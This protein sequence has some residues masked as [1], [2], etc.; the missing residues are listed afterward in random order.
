VRVPEALPDGNPWPLISIV[1]PS[2]NQADYLEATI[3]SVLLQGYPNLEYII[4]DGGSTDGTLDIIRKYEPWLTHWQSGADGGQYDGVQKGFEHSS[5]EIMA[6]LNSDDLY[7]PW[8]LKVAGEIFSNFPQMPWLTTALVAQTADG[9]FPI[10]AEKDN[11]S[12]RWFFSSNRKR[13]VK[14][15]FIQQEGTFWRRSLWD[16]A[17][18]RV[19][20]SLKYAGDFELWSR[21]YQFHIPVTVNVPLAMFRRQAQQKTTQLEKYYAEADRIL[22]RY[23]RMIRIPRFFIHVL[24]YIFRRTSSQ[25]NWFSTRSDKV[26]YNLRSKKWEYIKFLEFRF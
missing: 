23:P 16:E 12:K 3:R 22:Q 7:F 8:A 14:S 18:G 25:G 6:W 20:D 15:G 26:T 2:Y 5:G 21:F 9:D 17:G 1:T 11:Y 4:K 13:F 10:M 19:E 24:N